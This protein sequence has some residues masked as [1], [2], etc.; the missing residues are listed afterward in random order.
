MSVD[1]SQLVD[2]RRTLVSWARSVGAL[3][4]ELALARFAVAGW[5]AGGPHALAVAATL[6]DRVDRVAVVA[7]MPPP[8]GLG[9]MPRDTQRAVR[10]SRV[11]P[12]LTASRLEQ[13]GRRPVA[14]TGDPECDRAYAEG[15]AAAFRDGGLWLAVELA[16]LGR[17]WGFALRDVRARVTLWYGDTDRVTPVS[18]GRDFQRLLP[19]ATLRV[20]PEG[21]QLLFPRWREILAD[22]L[23][24]RQ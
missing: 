2:R 11:S 17:P 24:D 15:R 8:E 22:L 9:A 12:R 18:I 21:H 13:W 19:H 1:R 10:L 16:L 20:V 5:S 6:P 23:L 14:P 7:G 4:D 3:A